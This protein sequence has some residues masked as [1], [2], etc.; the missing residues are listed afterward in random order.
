VVSTVTSLRWT[1]VRP[2]VD[3]F[4]QFHM[5]T[6]LLHTFVFNSTVLILLSLR[7]VS[8]LKGPSSVISW[9]LIWPLTLPLKCICPT[10]CIWP[11]EGRN[12][13]QWH[14]VNEVVL[15]IYEC[16]SRVCVCETVMLVHGHEQFKIA[17]KA[18]SSALFPSLS[19]G[20]SNFRTTG[21]R[22]SHAHQASVAASK[23]NVCAFPHIHKDKPV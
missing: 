22:H 5:K 23:G 13:S 6:R 15:I 10:P 19:S 12:M 1:V 18:I 4:T 14:S 9:I 7:R 2:T 8:A 20:C 11:F 16:I 17:P 21:C 3:N